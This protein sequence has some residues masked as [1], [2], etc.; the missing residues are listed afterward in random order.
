VL[1]IH[2]ALE[3]VLVCEKG[4]AA[5]VLKKVKNLKLKAIKETLSKEETDILF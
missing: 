4:I 3:R 1:E 2:H 5:K